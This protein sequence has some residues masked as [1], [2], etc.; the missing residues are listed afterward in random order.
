[1]E[2]V[3]QDEDES[4]TDLLGSLHEWLKRADQLVR[5]PVELVPRPG[6]P[7]EMGGISDLILHL[8]VVEIGAAVSAVMAWLRLRGVD[9]D[10]Q[11]SADGNIKIRIRR[12]RHRDAREIERELV[13][14]LHRETDTQQNRNRPDKDEEDSGAD[15]RP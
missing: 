6:S 8:N 2:L 14:L 3:F 11:R 13:D 1:M 10:V 9:I 12:M 7:G 4:R 5:S 15:R